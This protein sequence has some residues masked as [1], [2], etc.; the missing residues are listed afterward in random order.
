M[1]Y[2][3][4]DKTLR[5]FNVLVTK[6][7]IIL[8]IGSAPSLFAEEIEL[9]E[10][11]ITGLVYTKPGPG[12][13]KIGAEE[14]KDKAKEVKK[15]SNE[16][17]TISGRLQVRGISAQ[18]DSDFS[19][20]HRDYNSF[21][22]NFRRVRFGF[23]Y[24]GDKWWG[25]QVHIRIENLINPPYLVESKNSSGAVTSEKVKDS[26]GGL[27]E[28]NFWFNVPLMKTKVKFGMA[29]H[30]F[31]REW[32]SSVNLVVVER[33]F[34]SNFIQQFDIGGFVHTHPLSLISE[35]LTHYMLFSFSYTNGKG[36]GHEGIGRQRALTET[37]SGKDPMFISP[38]LSWRVEV[39][40]FGGMIVNGK[41][42]DW[43]EG[44]DVFQRN[45]KVSL[46]MA[47]VT[48]RELR[49]VN[50]YN[51]HTK[52]VNSISLLS[53]QT[54]ATG[55]NYDVMN[56]NAGYDFSTGATN[57]FTPQYGL[58][59]HTYDMTAVWKGLYL[60]GAYTY[61]SGS[62]A[63]DTKT[64]QTTLG[65]NLPVGDYHVMPVVR[66]DYLRG[67]FDRNLKTESFERFKSYWAGINLYLKENNF[68]V[69][70]FYQILKDKL[71]T[72]YVSR[73]PIDANNNMI[74]FQMNMNIDLNVKLD[75]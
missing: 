3:A 24:N 69:Q 52:G 48:N 72:D 74:Y 38:M 23:K 16:K 29:K 2:Q 30:P 19:N 49:Y 39:N 12:R 67:D 60:S 75:K 63:K 17:L 1:D 9:Y 42:A 28:A 25:A 18:K 14:V 44:N 73:Q 40:P 45:L 22:M 34:V 56:A 58:N 57:P 46:G 10:D 21:D 15:P 5:K 27:Q 13:K 51:P 4:I 71:K 54:S 55:G 59:A 7:L 36:A 68:K 33:A 50:G 47:G 20:G 62:A 66:Y 35:K 6:L 65:Y 61:F 64:Y 37:H 32:G 41:E 31:L 70:L 11:P 53:P 8:C 43:D 26:R